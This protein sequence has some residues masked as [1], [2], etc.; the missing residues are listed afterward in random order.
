MV[1]ASGLPIEALWTA[2][3]VAEFLGVSRA[4][5][6]GAARKGA[7]PHIKLSGQTIRFIPETM[8]A[9][10]Q[11]QQKQRQGADVIKLRGDR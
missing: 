7:L 2:D 5:V 3:Q 1:D 11:E 8:R 4:W 6:Y 10:V 9:F